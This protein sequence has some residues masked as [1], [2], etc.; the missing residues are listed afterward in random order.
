MCWGVS[1][2][3]QA[4]EGNIQL[5]NFAVTKLQ[6]VLLLKERRVGSHLLFLLGAM[7]GVLW[8]RSCPRWDPGL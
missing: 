1:S 4:T 7:L 3:L 6:L 2:A 8:H 5:A